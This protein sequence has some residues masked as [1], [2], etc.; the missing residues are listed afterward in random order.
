MPR[1]CASSRTASRNSG[2]GAG[3]GDASSSSRAMARSGVSLDRRPG[4]GASSDTD[5]RQGSHVSR[6]ASYSRRSAGDSAPST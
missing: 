1:R 5:L 6:W 2:F 3:A 4:M